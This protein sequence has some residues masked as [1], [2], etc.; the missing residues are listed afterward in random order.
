MLREYGRK[1]VDPVLRLNPNT[2]HPPFLPSEKVEVGVEV[3]KKMLTRTSVM[4]EENLKES[5]NLSFVR[6][7]VKDL[8]CEI[9]F[10]WKSLPPI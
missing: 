5:P 2:K 3:I 7:V 4:V 1:T 10:V 9:R 6:K 8:K